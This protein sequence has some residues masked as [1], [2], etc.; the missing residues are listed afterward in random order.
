MEDKLTKYKE[1]IK[2][3]ARND[4]NE[5]LKSDQILSVSGTMISDIF[6]KDEKKV[7]QDILNELEHIWPNSWYGIKIR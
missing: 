6:K 4:D 2:W 5:W 3:I 1:A 7:K